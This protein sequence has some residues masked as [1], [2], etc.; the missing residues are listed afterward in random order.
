MTVPFA[1]IN[2]TTTLSVASWDSHLKMPTFML[3]FA[4]HMIDRPDS[5]KFGKVEAFYK[6]VKQTARHSPDQLVVLIDARDVAW[7]GCKTDLVQAFFET[8]RRV[9]FG[10]EYGCW[11]NRKLCKPFANHQ[12]IV[13]Q[14]SKYVQCDST[15]WNPPKYAFLNSGFIMGRASD[16]QMFYELQKEFPHINDD[17]ELATRTFLK[18]HRRH[19]WALDLKATFILNL[20]R[21]TQSSQKNST[22]S[23]FLQR[24]PCFIHGNGDGKTW[25]HHVF[26]TNS[27]SG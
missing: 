24:P 21:I 13:F 25:M 15:C 10:A 16:V 8:G 12:H 7:G 5:G 22:Y 3:P 23:L 20:Q 11:P 9:I 18:Y 4:V 17:Q 26:N 6:Y 14:T 27:E 2:I 1:A 19:H